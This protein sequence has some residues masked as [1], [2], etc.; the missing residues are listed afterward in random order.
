MAESKV[1]PGAILL[2]IEGTVTTIGFV[3]NTLFPYARL[4]GPP[5]I[6][7]HWNE[8]ILI[9]ARADLLKLN[10]VDRAEGAPVLVRSTIEQEMTAFVEYYLWLMERDRKTPPLKLIQGLVWERGFRDG[11]LR[12]EIFADVPPMLRS[13]RESGKLLATYSSGS[14]VAQQNVFRYSNHGDLTPLINAYFDTQIGS[15]RE[16]ASYR[17]IARCLEHNGAD[18]LFVS[19]SLEELESAAAAGLETRLSIRPGNAAISAPHGHK[20][21]ETFDAIP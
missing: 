3:Y 6:R 4:H 16:P 14:V 9:G 17:R 12:S 19:D 1:A 21:V 11:E 18:I 10:E 2:D 5:F 7:E 13:W 8:Q 15:K 20:T